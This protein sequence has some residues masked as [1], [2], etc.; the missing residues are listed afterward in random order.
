MLRLAILSFLLAAN[1][2]AAQT[3]VGEA[4]V[5][6][7]DTL[8]VAGERVHLHGVDAPEKGQWCEDAK[9]RPLPCGKNVA[10]V[11]TGFLK[12]KTVACEIR[13]TDRYQRRIGV[14]EVDGLDLGDTLVRAGLA[15]AYRRYSS[16]YLEAEEQAR[17]S[18]SGM[19]E[20]RFVKPSA[21]RR[22]DRL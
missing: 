1:A 9:A 3:L 15:F 14:C 11:L 20:G 18:G 22:G 6:D 5:I 16:D 21:W 13:G 12:G 2:V 10:I 8:E 4:R 17:R 7:G 19:W